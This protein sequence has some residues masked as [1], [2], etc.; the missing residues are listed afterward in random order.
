MECL[1]EAL[2]FN[3]EPRQIKKSNMLIHSKYD[4]SV[5]EQR[6]IL[7]AISFI[8]DSNN[9]TIEIPLREYKEMLGLE[10]FNYTHFN[11][12]LKKLKQNTIVMTKMDKRTGELEEGLITGWID[13]ISYQDATISLTFNDD[14]WYHLIDLKEKLLSY[15][16]YDLKIIL[17][18]QSKYSIRLFEIL[19]SVEFMGNYTIKIDEFRD[20]MFIGNKYKR[21]N[22]FTEKIL[23]PAVDEINNVE[24]IEVSYKGIKKGVKYDSIRFTIKKKQEEDK[25]SYLPPEVVAVRG[26]SEMDLLTSIKAILTFK[27]KSIFKSSDDEWNNAS[28]YSKYALETT[29]LSLME[30]AWKDHP[31]SNHKAFFAEHLRRLTAKG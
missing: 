22:D 27:H 10:S 18:L 15:T 29:Y 20:I 25:E 13:R 4:L 24:D 14:V 31:I 26:M 2:I 11:D 30:D 19:K 23:A 3:H 17:R 9:R 21:F 5:T 12:V 6:I 28:L 8:Q 16:K 7:I 1:M